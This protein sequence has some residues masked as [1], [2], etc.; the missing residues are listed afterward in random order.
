[1]IRREVP[2]CGETWSRLACAELAEV[3]LGPNPIFEI[4]SENNGVCYDR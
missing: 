4:T 1:L 3:I 2:L